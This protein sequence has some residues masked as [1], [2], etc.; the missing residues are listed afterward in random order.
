L[1]DRLAQRYGVRPSEF[2]NGS[3]GD[4]LFDMSVAI[5]GSRKDNEDS[6]G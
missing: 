2:M 5:E 3:Y 4:L 6:H 1:I